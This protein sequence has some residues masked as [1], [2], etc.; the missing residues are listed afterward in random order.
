MSDLFK[1]R[2]ST[3]TQ[4]AFMTPEQKAQQAMLSQLASTGKHGDINLGDA[5]TGSLGDFN[6]TDTQKLAGNRLYDLLNAGNPEGYNTARTTLTGLAN[7]KFNPDDPSSGY[8]AF[9]RQVARAGGVANDALN[10]E[11]AI[12]GD[13][14]STAIGRNKAD[15]GAQ[16]NDQ[17]ASKLGD[18]YNAAQDRSLNAANSLGNLETMQGN[19]TR[20]NLAAGFETQQGGLQQLLNTAKAQAD[21]N[22]FN[23]QRAEKLSRIDIGQNLLG[24]KYQWGQQSVTTK[25]PSIFGQM[26]GELN[27]L[28]GSYNTAKYGASNAPNQSNLADLSK[29]A[30]AVASMLGGGVA[31]APSGAS[32]GAF[33]GGTAPA[34][35][36][37][38]NYNNMSFSYL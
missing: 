17:L 7:N 33:G 13:R 26:Y 3:V 36:K 24:Q 9:Q 30:I 28:V 37:P 35:A 32:I 6:Q 5:Y 20:A 14:Y 2:S 10:R 12:T 4:D 27:P 8:A 19:N 11:A 21:Y 16:L 1:S 25:A 34:G 15:L 18:L 23:R 31:G 29:A 38:T 22:E